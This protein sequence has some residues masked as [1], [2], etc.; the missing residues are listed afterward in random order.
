LRNHSFSSELFPVMHT[1]SQLYQL[2]YTHGHSFWC[3]SI[4]FRRSSDKNSE[5][6]SRSLADRGQSIHCCW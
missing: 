3:R 4:L 5:P 1:N 6:R 2:V